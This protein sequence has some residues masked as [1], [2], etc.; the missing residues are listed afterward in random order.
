MGGCFCIHL[1]NKLSFNYYLSEICKKATKNVF[2]KFI[3]PYM[4]LSKIKILKNAFFKSQFSYCSLIWTC[5][6]RIINKK[7]NRLYERCLRIIYCDKQSSF[8]ELLEKES[9]VSMLERNIQMLA[10]E[11]YKV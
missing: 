3:A 10:T 6:S 2:D 7:L 11:M 9:S 8:E 1:E 4:N 5:Q